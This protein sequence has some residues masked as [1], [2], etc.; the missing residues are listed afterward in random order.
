MFK[1]LQPN[2]AHYMIEAAG[3]IRGILVQTSLGAMMGFGSQP[4]CKASSDLWVK[5]E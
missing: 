3:I 2:S 5:Q 1:T 4:R